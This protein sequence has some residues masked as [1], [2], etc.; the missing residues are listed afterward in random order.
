MTFDNSAFNTSYIIAGNISFSFGG[1]GTLTYTRSLTATITLGCNPV[2]TSSV[3]F[4][5]KTVEQ[6]IK[7]GTCEKTI[8]SDFGT[9][10][11]TISDGGIFRSSAS[12]VARTITVASAGSAAN[13]TIKDITISLAHGLIAN[14]CVD[15]GNNTNIDFVSSEYHNKGMIN[16]TKIMRVTV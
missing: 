9:V 3:D 8:V 10:S 12:G 5:G 1:A 2:G 13:A 14:N 15:G 7:T 6:V 16:T 11:I 4:G